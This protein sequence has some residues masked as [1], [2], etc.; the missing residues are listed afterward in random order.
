MH[1]LESDPL[2]RKACDA[3]FVDLRD[4][5]SKAQ[6]GFGGE[7][8]AADFWPLGHGALSAAEKSRTDVPEKGIVV[9]PNE[10]DDTFADE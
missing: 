1:R 5:E 2:F 6:C 7:Q 3:L 4:G 10:S 9:R 8:G